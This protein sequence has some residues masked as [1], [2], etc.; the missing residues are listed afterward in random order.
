VHCRKLTQELE[1]LLAKRSGSE[2]HV[3]AAVAGLAG[4]GSSSSSSWRLQ[5]CR[6]AAM[7][8]RLHSV[9]LPQLQVRGV[10]CKLLVCWLVGCVAPQLQALMLLGC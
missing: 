8:L 1:R 3:E 6:R 4:P 2:L 9:L 5:A 7:A 10:A